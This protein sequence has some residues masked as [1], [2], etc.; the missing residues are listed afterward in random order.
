[1]SCT[2]EA[3]F[4]VLSDGWLFPGWV[5]GASRMR[6]VD[7]L[8]PQVGSSLHHSFG[9]WPLL[10]NE[11]TTVDELRAPTHIVVRPKGW[12][13]GGSRVQIDIEPH[14]RGCRV[15]IIEKAVSGPAAR[16][17]DALMNIPLYLRNIETLKRLAY[18]AE[19]RGVS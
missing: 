5:V 17:P 2:P 15:R 4:A 16:V 14:L 3:V 9:V 18:I 7:D 1:M 12:P 13:L 10:I 8:W 11:E 19:G 6:A